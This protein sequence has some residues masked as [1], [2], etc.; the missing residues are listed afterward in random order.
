MMNNKIYNRDRLKKIVF[1]S[2]VYT[3]F[4]IILGGVF[5]LSGTLKL[6]DPYKFAKVLYAYGILP[7]FLINPV[8]IGLPLIEILSGIGL[9][10]NLV[11]SLELITG[12]LLM[13]IFVLWFGILN[14]L[15]IDCGC[16][17]TD[18]I[19]EQGGLQRALYRDF[20]F[21]ALSVFLFISR[22]V[23]SENMAGIP[24]YSFKGNPEKSGFTGFKGRQL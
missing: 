14:N 22:Y 21:I 12:M 7:D 15:N 5:V 6:I 13:F 2:V 3:S 8:A 23:N 17:S 10:F 20:V 16:F 18:E 4:R 11:L 9:V 19:S 24:F 1:S